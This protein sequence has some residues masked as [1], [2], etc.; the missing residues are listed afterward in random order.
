MPPREHA[1][2]VRGTPCL[3]AGANEW[4]A[5]QQLFSHRNDLLTDENAE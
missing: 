4:Q 1:E 2:E 3:V 5:R